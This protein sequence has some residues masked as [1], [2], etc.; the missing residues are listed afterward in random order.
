MKGDCAGAAAVVGA[1]RVIA[2]LRPQISVVAYLPIVENIIDAEAMLTTDV[3][4]MLDGKTVEII[5]TDAEGRLILADAITLAC[6]EGATTI[7]DIATLTGGVAVALGTKYAALF[8]TSDALS[9]AI[10]T[11]SEGAGER[12]WRLPLATVYEDELFG[13]VADLRNL[14]TGRAGTIV[15]ALFLKQF[16]TSSRIRWAHL[17]IAGAARV[18][19][20]NGTVP[21]LGVGT[22]ARFV[23]S[24]G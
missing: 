4:T 7:V 24:Q 13:G 11:A 15:A 20:E 21:G 3:I 12:F 8:A 1:M 16:V 17:D 10:I 6:Q 18:G 9:R 5:D 22:L 2:A 19:I 23:L 14:G